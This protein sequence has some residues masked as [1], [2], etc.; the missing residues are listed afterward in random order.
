M[1]KK[2][3]RNKNLNTIGMEIISEDEDGAKIFASEKESEDLRIKVLEFTSDKPINRE[4]FLGLIVAYLENNAAELVSV[5][6]D[7]FQCH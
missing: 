3:K 4:E 6:T 7:S 5:P 2:K 1:D